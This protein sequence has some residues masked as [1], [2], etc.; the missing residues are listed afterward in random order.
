VRRAAAWTF[1]LLY[2]AVALLSTVHSVDMFDLVASHWLA[3]LAAVASE[4]GAAACL[5]S[6]VLGTATGWTWL[7]FG[8]VT[9]MQVLGNVYSGFAHAQS[10]TEWASLLGLSDQE[11]VLQRR[12]LACVAGGVLPLVALGFVRQLSDVIRTQ[13]EP[14]AEAVIPE[15]PVAEAPS[16]GPTEEAEPRL[17]FFIDQEARLQTESDLRPEPSTTSIMASLD[18]ECLN[19]VNG[20][21]LL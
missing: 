4:L 17:P 8:L 9:G 21:S 6:A 18:E 3:V 1:G 14:A 12:V 10:P 7:L 15:A 20:C 5:A 13:P 2:L 16:A 19:T 11:V